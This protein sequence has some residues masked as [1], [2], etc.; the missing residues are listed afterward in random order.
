MVWAQK[1]IAAEAVGSVALL[2]REQAAS[3]DPSHR[4]LLVSVDEEWPMVRLWVCVP[5]ADLLTP[6]YGFTLCTRADL[7]LAPTLVAGCPEQFG[8]VLQG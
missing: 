5:E 1:R 2:F 7:P 6:Y 3:L 8:R 4:M